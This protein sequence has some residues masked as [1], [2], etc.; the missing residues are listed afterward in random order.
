MAR[1]K[2]PTRPEGP[3]LR[4]MLG[5]T[6][7]MGPLFVELMTQAQEIG[8]ATDDAVA[9]MSVYNELYPSELVAALEAARPA[10]VVS[11]LCTR[12]GHRYAVR[13]MPR[14]AAM[15]VIEVALGYAHPT[16]PRPT[17]AE[18]LDEN[19]SG[20]PAF[21][22]ERMPVVI[23]H[24][25]GMTAACATFI[26]LPSRDDA[27]LDSA[28]KRVAPKRV[29]RPELDTLAQAAHATAAHDALA[30]ALDLAHDRGLPATRALA[31]V[32]PRSARYAEPIARGLAAVQPHATVTTA[33]DHDG[34]TNILLVLP[35]E[36]VSLLDVAA[37][38]CGRCQTVSAWLAAT[39]REV[40]PPP[41]GAIAIPVVLVHAEAM[42]FTRRLVCALEGAGSA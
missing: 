3:T 40:P 10:V 14:G 24:P 12:R 25:A 22:P 9:I 11:S 6:E 7:D 1:P 36:R 27:A 15:P 5:A 8:L 19:L 34:A 41:P 23:A 37:C 18:W 20:A 17:A 32:T 38:G 29:P 39:E 42:S 26:A 33:F 31:I 30:A 2:K 28:P 13:I 35:R 21:G 16:G 4:Q